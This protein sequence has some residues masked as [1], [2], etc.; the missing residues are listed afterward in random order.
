MVFLQPML[1]LNWHLQ[2]LQPDRV[3]S[4]L[5]TDH[6]NPTKKVNLEQQSAPQ[7]W[8]ECTSGDGE[9]IIHGSFRSNCCRMT[10]APQQ[11]PH[12]QGL[13]GQLAK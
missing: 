1:T 9:T 11:I 4:S 5:D 12:F 13:F 2:P 6:I 8:R 3:I 7:E 10:S